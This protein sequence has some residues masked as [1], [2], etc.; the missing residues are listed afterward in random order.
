V[1]LFCFLSEYGFFFKFDYV[2]SELRTA[3]VW[4]EG[5]VIGFIGNPIL[6]TNF[7]GHVV[8]TDYV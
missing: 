7:V 6:V 1:G 3:Q 8:A 2:P 5:S 4:W